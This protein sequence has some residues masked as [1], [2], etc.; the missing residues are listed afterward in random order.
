MK[1]LVLPL[2]VAC[3]ALPLAAHAQRAVELHVRSAGELADLCA[4]NPREPGADA[5]INYC[6]GFAQGVVDVELMHG[7]PFCFPSPAPTRTATLHQ[8]VEWVRAAPDR[9]SQNPVNGLMQ[10][11]TQKYPCH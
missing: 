3:L 1:P 7:K 6:H 2:A 11:L 9:G 10:F 5:R 8:F 4:A